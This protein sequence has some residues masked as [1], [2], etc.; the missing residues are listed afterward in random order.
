VLTA[1]LG[2]AAPQAEAAAAPVPRAAAPFM[3]F[4]PQEPA[5]IP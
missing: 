1:A 5:W 2:R 3:P 4:L